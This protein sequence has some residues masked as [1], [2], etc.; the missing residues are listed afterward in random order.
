[1]PTRHPNRSFS[2]RL[3][4]GSKPVNNLVCSRSAVLHL[5]QRDDLSESY[6]G[7]HGFG[8]DER[9]NETVIKNA[10][11]C[12][13]PRH[14]SR[15][16]KSPRGVLIPNHPASKNLEKQAIVQTIHHPCCNA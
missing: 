8:F 15:P 7:V 6:C 9:I 16:A 1:M 11:V 12:E 4:G 3:V 14:V 13:T 2:F 5:F 10:I